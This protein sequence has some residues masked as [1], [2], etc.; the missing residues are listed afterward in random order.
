MAARLNPGNCDSLGGA[1]LKL[2]VDPRLELVTTL[3]AKEILGAGH[4]P[5][6]DEVSPVLPLRPSGIPPPPDSG[7]REASGA[8]VSRA[9]STGTAIS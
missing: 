6:H 7:T 9:L 5:N 8:D 4:T 3:V 1:C 2:K